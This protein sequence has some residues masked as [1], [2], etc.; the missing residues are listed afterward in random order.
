MVIIMSS[1]VVF[2]LLI[3]SFICYSSA[4][5]FHIGETEKKCFIEDI[6]DE[7]MVVGETETM[8]I[9]T[10]TR[11][12][13]TACCI[14]LSRTSYERRS[15]IEKLRL[16]RFF[17]ILEI[18]DIYKLLL[19]FPSRSRFGVCVISELRTANWRTGKTRTFS[20]N[21]CCEL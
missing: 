10:N 20:A 13:M 14:I 3:L 19:F 1:I 18:R 12:E 2:V 9:V 8:L 7:T 16:F 15:K 5:Y 6:P 11:K 21:F 4:L 17:T